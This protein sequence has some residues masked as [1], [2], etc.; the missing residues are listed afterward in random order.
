MKS[1]DIITIGF[2]LISSS[3]FAFLSKDKTPSKSAKSSSTETKN[4]SISGKNMS[5]EIGKDT[6]YYM[7]EAQLLFYKDKSSVSYSGKSYMVSNLSGHMI[8][9]VQQMNYMNGKTF[10]QISYPD[11]KQQTYGPQFEGPDELVELLCDYIVNG[12]MPASGV[13]ALAAKYK[14]IKKENIAFATPTTTKDKQ[15][16]AFY[17]VLNEKK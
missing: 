2:V 6:V 7:G 16:V 3:S 1:R 13:N 12:R 11:T 9:Y 5:M 8:A 17:N 14:L 15:L 4:K 10:Y